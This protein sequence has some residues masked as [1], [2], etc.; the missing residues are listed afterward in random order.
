MLRWGKAM[1][2]FQVGAQLVESVLAGGS[3][4]AQA[5]QAVRELFAIVRKYG[6]DAERAGPF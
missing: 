5:E 3:A 2:N 4:L 1:F 6:V